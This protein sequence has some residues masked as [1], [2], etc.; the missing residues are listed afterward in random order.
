[1]T[2]EA[3][4]LVLAR[5]RVV[6]ETD[7]AL[8]ARRVVHLHRRLRLVRSLQTTNPPTLGQLRSQQSKRWMEV[9]GWGSGIRRR[10]STTG[11]SC[12]TACDRSGWTQVSTPNQTE[13]HHQTTSAPA[14]AISANPTPHNLVW[15]YVISAQRN[16]GVATGGLTHARRRLGTSHGAGGRLLSRFGLSSGFGVDRRHGGSLGLRSRL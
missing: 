10:Q 13:P 8:T 9:K 16:G 11:S 7:R 2:Y 5:R 6:A 14:I 4:R 12:R 1:M 3:L 15:A